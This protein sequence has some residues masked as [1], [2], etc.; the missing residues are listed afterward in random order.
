MD[1]LLSNHS[2]GSPRASLLDIAHYDDESYLFASSSAVSR[3]VGWYMVKATGA[4]LTRNADSRSEPLEPKA[5]GAKV[6]VV[7]CHGEFSKLFDG[8]WIP[9]DA[10]FR[11]ETTEESSS[12]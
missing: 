10:L 6:F 4:M 12:E 2:I 3:H 8:G 11:P 5:A 7:Q 9:S 1:A